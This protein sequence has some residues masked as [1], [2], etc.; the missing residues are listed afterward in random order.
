MIHS[1]LQNLIG[2]SIKFTPSHGQI[3]ISYDIQDHWVK[4]VITDT[5]VGMAPDQLE[6][7]WDQQSSTTG[8]AGETGTGLGLLLCQQFV[9]RHGGKLAATSELGLGSTFSFTLPKAKD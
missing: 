4:I 6:R 1:V 9:E 8:T 3:R 2:N 5:G 7:L